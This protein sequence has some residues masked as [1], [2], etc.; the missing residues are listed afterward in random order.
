[1]SFP[2]IPDIEPNINLTLDDS[3]NLLLTSIALEEISLSK[4]I[5]AETGKI[6]LIIDESKHKESALQDT[7]EINKSVD[8]TLKNIIKLQ[9]LLQFKLE[10][11]EGLISTT[12]STTT[13]TTS[14]TTTTTT[15]TTTS[16][17]TSTTTTTRTTTSTTTTKTTTRTTTST[18]TTKTTTT[19]KECKCCLAGKG[20]GHISNC[21]DEFYG[22]LATLKAFLFSSDV[23]NR[24]LSY[25]VQNDSAKMQLIAS[26][27]EIKIQC[28]CHHPKNMVAYGKGCLKS[29]GHSGTVNFKL[30]VCHKTKDCYDIRM[31]ITAP[32]LELIHDSGIMQI[33]FCSFS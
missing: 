26:A 13:T 23:K 15:R 2:N 1:M 27:Y 12:T 21:D 32:N 9:M 30:Q 28:C 7:L 24:K 5:D 17:S 16:S 19:K 31:E 3:I 8:D 18:T 14:S 20:H 29:P 33:Q 22:C 4:L 10:R 6:L 25:K 11:V